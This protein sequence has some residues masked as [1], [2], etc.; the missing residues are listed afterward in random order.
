M[1]PKWNVQRAVSCISV[2]F[3]REVW[4]GDIKM[5]IINVCMALQVRRLDEITKG[6][7]VNREEVGGWNFG[8]LG[9]MMR[10]QQ[11]KLRKDEQCIRVRT[12][13]SGDL[14]FKKQSMIT[15]GRCC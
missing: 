12:K 13:R 9:E 10:N 5:G 8:L 7:Q 3:K 4:V 6:V 14:E 11:M 2:E 1:I 15:F